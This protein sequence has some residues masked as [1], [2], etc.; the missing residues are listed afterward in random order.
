MAWEEIGENIG[1]KI[2]KLEKTIE[3]L[4]E[5]SYNTQYNHQESYGLDIMSETDSPDSTSSFSAILRGPVTLQANPQTRIHNEA[6]DGSTL[7]DSIIAS[8]PYIIV[9]PKTTE[10]PITIKWILSAMHDGQIVV[11][12]PFYKWAGNSNTTVYSLQLQTGGNI[13]ISS[14]ITVSRN[15][16]IML[17]WT[18]N[19]PYY[20]GST[21]H[22][23][24]TSGSWTVLS[25]P[26]S[27]SSWVHTAT[28]PLNMDGNAIFFDLKVNNKKSI[29][30]N[31]NNLDYT[32]DVN[33]GAH[34]FY[35]DDLSSAKPR[36]SFVIVSNS[37]ALIF[38][39]PVPTITS[40]NL[41]Y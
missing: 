12:E 31:G 28:S 7:N 18:E 3:D 41:L 23:S 29:L 11:L 25:S 21:L 5:N 2:Y 22:S 1:D 35:V 32:V 36:N 19:V 34:N 8:G 37:S 6:Y 14:N 38:P 30:H 20:S 27:S 15:E 9:K 33:G 10:N 26:Q 13:N 40:F 17:Q 4:R 16:K 39:G 24:S